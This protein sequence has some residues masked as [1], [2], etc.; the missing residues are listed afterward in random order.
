MGISDRRNHGC[1]RARSPRY[2][3][4]SC[5]G[6]RTA[7]G[8]QGLPRKPVSRRVAGS[9]SARM[10]RSGGTAGTAAAPRDQ[11]DGTTGAGRSGREGRRWPQQ[12]PDAVPE[13]AT[14]AA[15]LAITTTVTPPPVSP[16]ARRRPESRPVPRRRAV[17]WFCI[18]GISFLEWMR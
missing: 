13:R 18:S 8:V 11:R 7:Q 2:E 6:L 17:R 9:C 4:E 16:Q 15:R 1:V 10:P 5:Q 12:S 3:R 14:Q